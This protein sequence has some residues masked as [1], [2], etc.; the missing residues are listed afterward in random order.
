MMPS[1]LQVPRRGWQSAMVW[2]VRFK[3]ISVVA[4]GAK[5]ALASRILEMGTLGVS[6]AYGLHTVFQGRVAS[7]FKADSRIPLAPPS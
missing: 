6:Q 1:L 5:G 7:R 4:T 3:T 2:F